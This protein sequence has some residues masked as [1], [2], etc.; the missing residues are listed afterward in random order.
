MR[1]LDLVRDLLDK[2]VIDRDGATVGKVDTIVLELREGK[3]PRVAALEIGSVA[4]ARRLHAGL[5]TIVAGMQ[6][7]VGAGDGEALRVSF[8]EVQEIGREVR[9]DVRVADTPALAWE[10]WLRRTVVRHLPGGKA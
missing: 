4:V 1:A 3:P 7:L 2:H 6:R 9:V 5:G 10:R 8:P